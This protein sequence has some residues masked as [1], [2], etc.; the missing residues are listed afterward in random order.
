M[1]FAVRIQAFFKLKTN[2]LCF[3]LCHLLDWSMVQLHYI[4]P[5]LGRIIM[6]RLPKFT[7]SST[8]QYFTSREGC[9]CSIRSRSVCPTCPSFQIRVWIKCCIASLPCFWP[10]K[11]V[12][13]LCGWVTQWDRVC[14]SFIGPCPRWRARV[15][16]LQTGRLVWYTAD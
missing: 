3:R 14:T 11:M 12:V 2:H 15:L 8:L 1:P 5:E 4:V 9:A 6:H 13:C 7:L 16:S 10:S